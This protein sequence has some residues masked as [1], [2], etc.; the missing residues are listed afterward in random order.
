MKPR[1]IYYS[2]IHS[3][4]NDAFAPEAVTASVPINDIIISRNTDGSLLSKY[5]DDQWDLSPY[6]GNGFPSRKVLKFNNFDSTHIPILKKIIFAHLYFTTNR[7]NKSISPTTLLAILSSFKPFCIFASHKDMTILQLF[8]S[9]SLFRQALR[10]PLSKRCVKQVAGSLR[11]LRSVGPKLTGLEPF[12]D[13]TL[14]SLER[15]YRSL[16]KDKQIAV[17]PNRILANLIK[18]LDLFL[19]EVIQNESAL[20]E[21]VTK[22]HSD[23]CY[24]RHMTGQRQK[25]KQKGMFRPFFPTAAAQ[26]GL[27]ELT[28][29]HSISSARGVSNFISK[30]QHACKTVIEIFTGMRR[31]EI[32]SLEMGCLIND[33]SDGTWYIT[34]T[35]AKITQEQQTRWVT[36]E[37]TVKAIRLAERISQR[38][39]ALSDL[40]DDVM[41]LFP[42][43]TYLNLAPTPLEETDYVR[44]CRS[45]AVTQE[46]YGSL[47]QD[48]FRIEH[49]DAEF[50][51]DVDPFRSWVAEEKFHVG[52]V[53]RFTHH[54]FRRSLAFYV[55]QSGLVSLPALKFQLKHISKAMTIYYCQ[56]HSTRGQSKRFMNEFH[57]YLNNTRPEAS[58][59]AYYRDVLTSDD[60]FLGVKSKQIQ[61]IVPRELDA[62][63]L[64]ELRGDLERQYRN[65]RIAYSPTPLGACMSLE[66]CS[67]RPAILVTDCLNC[68]SALIS[69]RKLE[70]VK[71]RQAALV[72][73]CARN[74]TDD[75]EYRL[76]SAELE[77]LEH[78]SNLAKVSS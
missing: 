76:E 7:P 13:S 63:V 37:N 28:K 70:R 11:H 9:K 39:L 35:A 56:S 5:N 4:N 40:P 12:P 48:R 54:Q 23:N 1:N 65:A 45:S 32:L 57:S 34:G 18:E 31:I 26:H 61:K 17:I 36:A 14:N 19:E 46:V 30:I 42:S 53:W 38:I 22:M 25:G 62:I 20:F 49:S 33:S 44:L 60:A 73:A 47:N 15:I 3:Y 10:V 58:A 50:L 41:P 67:T 77:R 24:G 68:K 43:T 64:K 72:S 29:K 6:E 27:T 8:Q 74:S 71:D 55:S 2:R 21:L 52:K 78:F 75:F 69:K 51:D 16:P 66:R 59:V